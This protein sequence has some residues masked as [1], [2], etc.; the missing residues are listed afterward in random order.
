[1]AT[2]GEALGGLEDEEDIEVI[3]TKFDD[4]LNDGGGAM[5][6]LGVRG[7]TLV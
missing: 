2:G 1:M 7:L 5:E 6:S 3:G 4:D